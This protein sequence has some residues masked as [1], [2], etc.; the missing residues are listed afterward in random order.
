MAGRAAVVV[1]PLE[2]G[3]LKLL[4]APRV[5]AA[6]GEE[7]AGRDG[8]DGVLCRY[9]VPDLAREVGSEHE[10]EAAGPMRWVG[11]HALRLNRPLTRRARLNRP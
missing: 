4:H 11:R 10:L 8:V 3:L 5:N 7:P 2:P 6:T 9:S 1:Q